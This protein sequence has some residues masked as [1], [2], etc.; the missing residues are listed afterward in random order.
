MAKYKN[1]F[2]E[3][4]DKSYKLIEHISDGGNGSVWKVEFDNGFYA[5]KFLNE[6]NAEKKERFSKE[7]E[8]CVNNEHSNLVKIYDTGIF[9]DKL[10]YIMPLYEKTLRDIIKSKLSYFEYMDFILQI[11]EG[12]KFIHDKNVIH[13]DIKPENILINKGDL[14]LADLGIAHFEDSYQTKQNDLLANRNYAAPEQKNKGYSRE[15]TKAADIYSLGCIINEIFT[16]ENPLGT[17]FKIVSDIY[18]WLWKF[19]Y[20]IERCMNQKPIERPTIEEIILELKLLKGETEELLE[21]ISIYITSCK[22]YLEFEFSEEDLLN[23]RIDRIID[24]ASFDVMTAKYLFENLESNK[25]EKYNHNYNCDI[26]YCIDEWMKRNYFDRLLYKICSKKFN[27]E[28][29]VYK[30]GNY[31]ESLKLENTDDRQIYEEFKTIMLEHGINNGEI[32]KLF[33]SCCD[34]H[35]REII[36]SA[37]DLV[38]IVDSLDDAPI[39]YIVIKL[40][41]CFDNKLIEEHDIRIEEH[42]LINWDLTVLNFEN[43]DVYVDMSLKLNEVDDEESSILEKL[44]RR[45]NISYSKDKDK[46]IVRFLDKDSYNDFKKHSLELAKPYYIFEGDVLD[47]IKINRSY[48]GIIELYPLDDFEVKNVLAKILGLRYDY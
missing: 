32:L 27:Y 35:C 2:I 9:D 10:F 26:H 45:W 7:I 22:K 39:L 6:E 20:L 34:Y 28:S 38:K 46:Y 15:V 33:S 31:Y 44:N 3:I 16:N 48:D 47:L 13:R 21:D 8:F 42:I 40:K 25:L 41:K 37:N 18:P 14:V 43:T 17:N 1:R 11:C 4:N 12:L 36:R 5:V 19:D 29:N 30:T 23:G 24:R